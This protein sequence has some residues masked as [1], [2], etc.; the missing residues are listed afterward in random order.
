M[1]RKGL[2][3]MFEFSSLELATNKFCESNILG[4]GGFGCVYKA[5]FEGGLLGA[6]KRLEGGSPDCERE[7]EVSGNGIFLFGISKLASE[8]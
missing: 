3:A 4:V 5:K 2:V 1:A 8:I 6:V 7:F